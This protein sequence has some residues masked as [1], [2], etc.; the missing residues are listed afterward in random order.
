MLQ[1]VASKSMKNAVSVKGVADTQ[2]DEDPI[3]ESQTQ[4][5]D[6]VMAILARLQAAE[7]QN[8][9]LMLHLQNGHPK[10]SAN[11]VGLQILNGVHQPAV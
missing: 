10:T 9:K 6:A 1:I 2:L 4:N 5:S 3:E 11:G 8:K 7:E